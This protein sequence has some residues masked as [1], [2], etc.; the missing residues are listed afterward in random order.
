MDERGFFSVLNKGI[1]KIKTKMK[2][3]G[4]RRKRRRNKKSET[5]K[6]GLGKEEGR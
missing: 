5:G 6:V 1:L 2:M 3:K 4:K